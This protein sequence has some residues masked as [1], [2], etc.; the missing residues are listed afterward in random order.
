MPVFVQGHGRIGAAQ[1]LGEGHRVHPLLQCPGHE[2]MTQGVKVGLLD[3]RPGHTA[4]EQVLVGPGLVGRSVFLAEYI[5]LR[6]VLWV[7]LFD[8]KLSVA[9]GKLISGLERKGLLQNRILKKQVK[10]KVRKNRQIG[11]SL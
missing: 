7:L 5:A 2:G 9:V 8:G 4:F 11:G 3:A 6:I 1:Q 10:E